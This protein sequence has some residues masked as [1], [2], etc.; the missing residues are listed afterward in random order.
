MT[1]PSSARRFSLLIWPLIGAILL[2]SCLDRRERIVVG[3]D[4]SVAVEHRV[5]GDQA[6]LENGAASVP[7]APLWNAVKKRVDD[8]KWELT[9]SAVFASAEAVP[10]SFAAPDDPFA[11]LQPAFK[12]S[13]DVERKDGKV[14]RTFRRTYDPIPYGDFAAARRK[15]IPEEIENAMK[16]NDIV[17]TSAA[18]GIAATI[19][20]TDA[21]R[22]DR[23]K[24]TLAALVEYERLKHHVY[25]ERTVRALALPRPREARTVL[26]MKAAVDRYFAAHLAP[27]T[28]EELLLSG[29]ATIE[30]RAKEIEGELD[31]AILGAM[32]AAELSAEESAAAKRALLSARRAFAI[33]DDLNDEEFVITV[34]LPGKI[35]AHDGTKDDDATV[36]FRF[37]AKDLL[38]H[39]VV[40]TA[41]SEAKE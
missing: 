33:G 2:P 14:I 13:L 40:L 16:S 31:R 37:S 28:I 11:A 4:G 5:S 30:R 3:L 32:N 34:V 8:S 25:A 1:G 27:K 6:D 38:D 7:S 39:Q 29:D 17:R 20:E 19:E 9:A 18:N 15:A 12:T 41:I 24:K 10:G 35:T 26:A 22:R 36:T 23:E 21:A